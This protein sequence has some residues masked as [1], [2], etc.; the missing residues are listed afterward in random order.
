MVE[1]AD[2]S[3]VSNPPSTT[4]PAAAGVV[5]GAWLAVAAVLSAS[6][7]LGISPNADYDD[8]LKLQKI[9]A[10]LDGAGWFDR[11]VPGILQPGSFVSHWPRLLDLPYALAARLV[12]PLAGMDRA[13]DAAA[14][15]VPLLL[16]L[17]A[18]AAYRRVIAGLGFERQDLVFLLAL[19]PAM[20]AL[21]EF[22]PF[23]VDYHNVQILFLLASL[24]LLFSRRPLAAATN[25]ALIAVALATSVEF[26]LFFALA[27]AVYAFDFVR[28]D[29]GAARRLASFGAGL[30]AAG[31][32]VF[33]AVASPGDYAAVR[34]DIYSLPHL[35]ALALAGTAFIVAGGSARWT[36]SV[37]TR[38]LI[39]ALPA[40][41]GLAALA[42]LYPGCL[43]GPYGG[44]SDYL[45]QAFIL[46]IPQERSLFARPDFVLSGSMLS[47]ALLFVGATAPAVIVVAGRIRDRRLVVFALFSLLALAQAVLYTRNLRYLPLFGGPGLL[48]VLAALLPKLHAPGALFVG[49]FSGI[50]RSP[51]TMLAPGLTLAAFVVAVVLARP[52]QTVAVTAADIAGSCGPELSADFDWPVGARIMATPGLG[53]VLLRSL[54][55]DDAV[56][57]APF[58][59]AAKGLERAYRF[60]DPLTADPEA[61]LGE[62]EATHVVVCSWRWE[63]NRGL[64]ARYPLTVG[65]MQGRPPGWLAEC[66]GRSG[67]LVRT[68]RYSRA[69]Q[70][71][72]ACPVE[73]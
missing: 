20:R 2:R 39:I 43:G 25:G 11:V 21:Y 65:L 24:A 26:A 48:F 27:M 58:H 49:R 69:G 19:V 7:S 35:T 42:L 23:R 15:A 37:P 14:F 28:A 31:I 44:M 13:L 59:T 46:G 50:V 36:G 18:L 73:R 47:G 45:Y 40:L 8:L 51:A 4:R 34:C 5:I 30:A 60:F 52:A 57:A 55:K 64:E 54:G 53:A 41:A 72:A 61:I 17:A 29:E 56:V 62:T 33:P 67:S 10:F 66:P 38:A 9:R 6:W 71:A 70:P 68:Y 1:I 63:P 16:L 32:A 12:E 22:A 3:A